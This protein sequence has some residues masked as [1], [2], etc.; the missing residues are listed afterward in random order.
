MPGFS[1]P[2]TNQTGPNEWSD[3]EENDVRLKERIELLEGA[4]TS[5]T[6]YPPKVIGNEQTR[7]GVEYGLLTIPDEITGIVVPENA[8]VSRA[9]T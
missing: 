4:H 1:L 3:V 6:W 2:R 9:P 5:S 7:S 8:L